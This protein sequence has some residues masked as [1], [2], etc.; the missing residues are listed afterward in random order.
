MYTSLFIALGILLV[1]ML[2]GALLGR[3]VN[4]FCDAGYWVLYFMVVL[5]GGIAF[6]TFRT[7]KLYGFT[8]PTKLAAT[9]A[10]LQEMQTTV[11]KM[12][13]DEKAVLSYRIEQHN[14]ECYEWAEFV[15]S[16][17]YLFHTDDLPDVSVF[18]V[19]TLVGH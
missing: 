4:R 15:D 13:A 10:E 19:E 12:T 8:I 7:G 9:A 17:T 6:S 14:Q 2:V 1:G 18:L 3:L 5:S 16:H 11:N